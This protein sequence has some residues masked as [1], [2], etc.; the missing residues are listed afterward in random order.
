MLQT[1]VYTFALPITHRVQ[2]RPFASAADVFGSYQ[3]YSDWGAGV[4]IP[5]T[6]FAAMWVNSAWMCPVYV[7]EETKNASTETPKSIVMTYSVTAAAGL[8]V[9]LL[10]AFCITDM[11]AAGV[12]ER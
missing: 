8:L 9:C 5:Y 11:D 1:I 4:A 3:S 2:G 6:W 12:D 10:A 7:A